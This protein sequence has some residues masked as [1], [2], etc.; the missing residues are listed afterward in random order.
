MIAVLATKRL[1]SSVDPHMLSHSTELGKEA[2]TVWTAEWFFS[3]VHPHVY[4]KVGLIGE[5]LFTHGAMIWSLPC[6]SP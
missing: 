1:L 2:A 5:L 6:M 3:S 4:N